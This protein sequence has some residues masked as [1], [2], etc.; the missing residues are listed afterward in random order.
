[1]IQ[2]AALARATVVKYTELVRDLIGMDWPR[3]GNHLN[4]LQEDVERKRQKLKDYSGSSYGQIPIGVVS[5]YFIYRLSRSQSHSEPFRFTLNELLRS[6]RQFRC[7]DDRDRVFGLV[8]I[9][10]VS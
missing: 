3:R 7:K 4:E 6:I 1:M 2:E 5:V 8:E 9:P 10:T